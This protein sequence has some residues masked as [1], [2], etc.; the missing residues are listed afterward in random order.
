M[1]IYTKRGLKNYK[2]K[3]LLKALEP[4][5]EQRMA[6]DPNFGNQ[7]VPANS[8]ADLQ[9]MYNKYV[10]E[11]IETFEEINTEKDMARKRSTKIE[12]VEFE[13]DFDSVDEQTPA[14]KSGG[15]SG[16]SNTFI[17]PF[18]REEPIVRDYVMGDESLRKGN[19]SAPADTRSFFKEPTSFEEAFEIPSDEEADESP[20]AV[21]ERRKERVE[22][23]P[24]NPDFDEMNTGKKKRS[25]K[26]F[27]K[28]IVEAVSVLS[29]KGFVWYANND[30]NDAKLAEYE[31]SGEMDLS[32]LVSLEDGQEVS[33]KQFFQT[34]CAKAELLAK[35]T[36]EQKEDLSSALAE[37]LMEKGVA[38]TPTQELLLVTLTI[39]GGQAMTLFALKSQT[40][41]LLTQL[42]AMKKT[43]ATQI[44]DSWEEMPQ[45]QAEKP[46]EQPKSKAKEAVSNKEVEFDYPEESVEQESYEFVNELAN[47][48]EE[49]ILMSEGQFD[50]IE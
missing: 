40:N 20:K 27:A 30:I 29:E 1:K 39:V 17:D 4:I 31:M 9:K 5:L 12:D 13:D 16:K 35:W 18:N 41:S 24:M 38:P 25:T 44:V 19:D 11:D 32:L 45:P 46:K 3:K 48:T 36:D 33:V 14:P 26:K 28:Y 49:E 7:F 6:E 23:E 43:E 21:K 47:L 15:Q 42:R 50:T 10:V 34:Q 22:S 37:V 8:Y 2:E